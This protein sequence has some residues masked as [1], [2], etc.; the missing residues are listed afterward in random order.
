MSLPRSAVVLVF[1]VERGDGADPDH[2]RAAGVLGAGRLQRVERV[3]G[4]ARE[5]VGA[6]GVEQRRADR[7]GHQDAGGQADAPVVDVGEHDGP[8]ARDRGRRRVDGARGAG[9]VGDRVGAAD[10][11]RVLGGERREAEVLRG[12]RLGALG[13]GRRGGLRRLGVVACRTRGRSRRPAARGRRARRGGG[14]ASPGRLRCG[15]AGARRS[16]RVCS[17]IVRPPAT[18]GTFVRGRTNWG[19]VR[20]ADRRRSECNLPCGTSDV[21][22]SSRSCRFPT[23]PNPGEEPGAGDPR[24]FGANSRSFPGKRRLFPR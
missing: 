22:L 21:H 17:V 20:R 16:R 1:G 23:T 8:G 7:R 24:L 14:S 11:G 6:V 3:L 18:G 19:Q 10:P 2:L 13:A 9:G 4:R 12:G 15:A 5:P